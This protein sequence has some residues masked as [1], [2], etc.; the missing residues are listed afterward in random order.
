MRV[1]IEHAADAAQRLVLVDGG[2][3]D[4][5]YM[6]GEAVALG[7]D[8]I[9]GWYDSLA[10]RDADI[11]SNPANH[12]G[13]LPVTRWFDSRVLTIHGVYAIS[14]LVGASAVGRFLDRLNAFAGETVK[15]TVIDAQ[16]TRSVTGVVSAQI[17]VARKTDRACEWSMIVTCADPFKYGSPVTW[18]EAGGRL[19]VENRGT[20]SVLPSVTVTGLPTAFSFALDGHEV[21]WTGN[22]G[23]R[24]VSLDFAVMVPSAGTV[25]T[26]DAF[27][28]PPGRS[29][30]TV[31]TTPETA[32]ASMVVRDAW[33]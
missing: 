11:E 17:P 30:V 16:G 7:E 9:E 18:A 25:G 24:S 23:A 13:F 15:V 12:G 6:V 8:G 3:L 21:S 1:I 20:A 31:E 10:L 32:V 26:D 2:T 33:R 29:V 19:V 5:L 28:I 22:G 27:R 14:S 4:P